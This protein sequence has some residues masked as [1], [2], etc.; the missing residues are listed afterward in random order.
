MMNNKQLGN[1]IK[2]VRQQLGYTQKE[3]GELI[4]GANS[5]L[6]SKW[7]RGTT[8][9]NMKRQKIIAEL[10]DLDVNIMFNDDNDSVEIYDNNDP[11]HQTDIEHYSILLEEYFADIVEEQS[12]RLGEPFASK[13]KSLDIKLLK[14]KLI[15]VITSLPSVIELEGDGTFFVG[16]LKEYK[17]EYG[18]DYIETLIPGIITDELYQIRA[19]TPQSDAEVLYNVKQEVIKV[20]DKIRS[21]YMDEYN[22]KYENDELTL[23]MYEQISN[24]LKDTIFNLVRLEEYS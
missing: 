15:G 7:E 19:H 8:T 14:E 12:N 20:E 2:A 18:E 23:E 11:N 9:P 6:V 5:S 22:K 24:A 17:D 4:D 3:F 1:K 10:A 21:Y 13:F 16:T